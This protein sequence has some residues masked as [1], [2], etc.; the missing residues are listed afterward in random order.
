MPLLHYPWPGQKIGS[1]DDD[2]NFPVERSTLLLSLG[3]IPLCI[4]P[5]YEK[6]AALL[7][8]SVSYLNKK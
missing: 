6:E 4:Q 1:N 2:D 3:F 7:R 8:S 5:E